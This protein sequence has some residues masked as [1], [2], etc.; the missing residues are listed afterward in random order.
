M[1]LYLAIS[2]PFVVPV[3][4]RQWKEHQRQRQ[5]EAEISKLRRDHQALSKRQKQ[6]LGQKRREAARVQ[7]PKPKPERRRYTIKPPAPPAVPLSMLYK[8]DG[9]TKSRATSDRLVD[10]LAMQYPGKSRRWLTE[11]AIADLERDRRV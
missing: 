2:A 6:A 8:L 7:L 10:G 5:K 11:K 4:Y 3:V 1:A 9:L